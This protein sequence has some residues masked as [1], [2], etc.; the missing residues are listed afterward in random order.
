MQLIVWKVGRWREGAHP[1]KNGVKQD[2]KRVVFKPVDESDHET[3]YINLDKRFPDNV[4]K[5]EKHLVEGNVLDVMIM[6]RGG[7]IT[8]DT[9][10]NKFERF[11]VVK[12]VDKRNT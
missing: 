6:P 10:V 11:T 9:T 5:W 3:Y 2:V 12:S 7:Y 8:N 1:D 4:E